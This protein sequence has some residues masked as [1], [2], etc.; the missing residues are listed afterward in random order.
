[1]TVAEPWATVTRYGI[2]RDAR[3][4]P[5]VMTLGGTVQVSTLWRL[6]RMIL[7]GAAVVVASFGVSTIVP[8]SHP[9]IAEASVANSDK[10]DKDK[11]DKKDNS[12]DHDADHVMNGQ[13]IDMNTLKDPPEL[14]VGSVD[15]LT[16]IKVLKTDEI[17]INGIH[18]GDYVQANGEKINEQLFEATELSVSEHY[19][20]VPAENDNK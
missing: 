18:L 2:M 9:T 5:A 1:M 7:V 10:D 16:T 14:Y 6:G 3:A 4:G 8:S 12:D 11:K 17:A 19:S 15:G 13:V 20:D